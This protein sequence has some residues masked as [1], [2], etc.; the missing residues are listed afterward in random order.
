[1]RG[2][3]ILHAAIFCLVW[4]AL[5]LPIRSVTSGNEEP[6]EAE[7]AE[8]GSE[9]TMTTCWV[10]LQFSDVPAQFT[11]THNGGQL[12]THDTASDPEPVSR[13]E[14]ELKLRVDQFGTEFW[15]SAE[16]PARHAA[17]EI[18]V[19]PDERPIRSRTLWVTGPFDEPV[20]FEWGSHRD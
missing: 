11:V 18:M 7:A 16:L 1:M 17:V 14:R 19:Q 4:A 2:N 10:T 15:L 12:W 8:P 20:S 3:P 13:F 9:S 5:I 6:V